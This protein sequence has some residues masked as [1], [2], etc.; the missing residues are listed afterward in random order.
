VSGRPAMVRLIIFN[1]LLI[2]SCGYALWRGTRDAR[3]V[4][5]IC[6]AASAATYVAMSGYH[7]VEEDI[8]VI[9][10]LV[11]AGFTWIAMKSDRF[12]PLWVAG[13]QLTTSF[14]HFL[15]LYQADLVPIAYAVALRMWSYPIQIILAVAVWRGY[16]RMGAKRP[17]ADH[18]S[19][20]LH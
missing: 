11:L 8:L 18:S 1:V 2:G 6:L 20:L 17:M 15:K 10:L 12:W 19:P 9:D 5:L 14:G 16:R 4:A 7:S 13:L 3:A